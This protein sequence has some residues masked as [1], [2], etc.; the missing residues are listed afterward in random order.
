MQIRSKFLHKMGAERSLR[1]FTRRH[2]EIGPLTSWT[3][4][5]LDH[6][7]D[8]QGWNPEALDKLNF[9]TR[10]RVST[11]LRKKILSPDLAL[12]LAKVELFH[13]G[14]TLI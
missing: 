8:I 6:Y 2:E 13:V 3:L 4:S 11:N 9:L 10:T 12:V 7:T 1:W 14:F 5:R